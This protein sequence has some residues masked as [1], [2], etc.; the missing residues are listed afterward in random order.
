MAELPIRDALW[1]FARHW[2]KCKVIVHRWVDELMDGWD[3]NRT[4]KLGCACAG[5]CPDGQTTPQAQNI[6]KWF[7][8]HS[9]VMKPL[10]Q[11]S[12]LNWII[13]LRGPHFQQVHPEQ[14]A[15]IPSPTSTFPTRHKS[16][17]MTLLHDLKWDYSAMVTRIIKCWNIY[18]KHFCSVW[19][20]RNV[21][22]GD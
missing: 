19:Y 5:R 16:G 18:S 8:Y 4:S 2:S 10:L 13:V 15:P 11:E 21:V 12:S 22:S 20:K 17:P 3:M 9:L 7:S 1:R 14:A 6:P